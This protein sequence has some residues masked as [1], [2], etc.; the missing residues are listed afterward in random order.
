MVTKA[1]EW[2]P[3]GAGAYIFFSRQDGLKNCLRGRTHRIYTVHYS[4][5]PHTQS[6]IYSVTACIFVKPA[7]GGVVEI[8]MISDHIAYIDQCIMYNGAN[9]STGLHIL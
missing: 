5:I 7:E 9:D 8:C 4:H 3:R 6:S 2:S 1:G